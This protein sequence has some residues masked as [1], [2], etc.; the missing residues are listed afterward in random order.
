ML[1]NIVDNSIMNMRNGQT[2][3]IPQGSVLMDFIAEMVLGYA[4]TELTS[5]IRELEPELNY[6]VLRYRDDYRIFVTQQQ[7]GEESSS[8]LRKS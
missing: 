3:G 4:D 5:K 7:H 8:A 2:N 1:G 6:Q